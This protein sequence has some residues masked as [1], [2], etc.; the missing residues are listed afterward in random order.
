MNEI[1][2]L[3]ARFFR[4]Y[5]FPGV[6]GCI[7]C[8]NVANEDEHIYVNRKQYHSLNVQLICDENLKIMNVVARFPGNA[9]DAHIWR[10]C[11]MAQVMETIYRENNQNLFSC[12]EIQ[13]IRFDHGC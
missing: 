8:T 6:V 13:D 3:R 2:D 10:Q 9:H 1:Q 5:N 4:Q 11:N 12:W 7:D